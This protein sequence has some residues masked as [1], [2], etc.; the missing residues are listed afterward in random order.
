MKRL[1]TSYGYDSY[2]GRSGLRTFL[3]VLAAVLAVVL[4]LLIAAFFL[5]QD[6]IYYSDDGTAHVSLP[7]AEQPEES[8]PAEPVVV[9]TAEPTPT[10][11]PTAEPVLEPVLLPLSALTDGTAQEQVTAAKGSAAVFDMK[12]D[13]G[14]LGYVSDLPLAISLGTSQARP[15]LNEAIRTTNETEGL[16]TIARVSCFK[17]NTAPRMANRLALRTSI[18]NW[19]DPEGV[20]WMSPAVAEGADYIAAVCGEL[21]ALGF[22]EIWLDHAAY[23]VEGDLG[24]ITRNERYDPAAFQETLTAFYGKVAA[25]LADHPEVKVSISVSPQLLTDGAD[26]SGQS[27]ELLKTYACRVWVPGAADEE[28]AKGYEKA[29]TAMGLSPVYTTGGGAPETAASGDLTG[30]YLLRP[31]E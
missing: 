7:W 9:V 29:L 18:G 1:K 13:Q 27:A 24:F 31:E 30:G 21:A 6:H 19:R 5:L 10:P 25:A 12:S 11:T 8:L 23:P 2:R 4:V 15:G 20:R 28:A 22:D 3:K 26:H 16:Y 17:D 14:D